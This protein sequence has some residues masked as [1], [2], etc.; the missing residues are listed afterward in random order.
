MTIQ[1]RTSRWSVSSVTSVERSLLTWIYNG[2]ILALWVISSQTSSESG[3]LFE[4]H[5]PVPASWEQSVGSSSTHSLGICCWGGR[6]VKGSRAK[7]IHVQR[8]Q[9]EDPWRLESSAAMGTRGW[10]LSAVSQGKTALSWYTC[11]IEDPWS[12]CKLGTSSSDD[13]AHPL[14]L[15]PSRVPGG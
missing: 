6:N 13:W 11:D 3:Q 12:L 14:P 4:P 5:S 8:K 2:Q 7:A 15:L 1:N 9:Q 10:W